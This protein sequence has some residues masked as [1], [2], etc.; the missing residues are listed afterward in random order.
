MTDQSNLVKVFTG[1]E[2]TVEL[3]KG[4]L[5]EIG[6]TGIVKNEF[7]SGAVAGFG[8]GPFSIEYYILESDLKKA[9]PILS[10]FSKNN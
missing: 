5:Q 9:E 10:E 7:Q 8:G 6:I 4:K 2:V 1:T 3:L